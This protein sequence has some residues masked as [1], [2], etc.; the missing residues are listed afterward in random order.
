MRQIALT[1]SRMF[2]RNITESKR[3]TTHAF[4]M[5]RIKAG[6]GRPLLRQNEMIPR[7]IF[8]D[9]FVIGFGLS[10]VVLLRVIIL[11]EKSSFLQL[12]ECT[13]KVNA[14]E[15]QA[16]GDSEKHHHK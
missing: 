9:I 6:C 12:S 5:T 7:V 15:S 4:V 11:D 10:I 8:P 1:F 13:S 3:K 14:Q 2:L 16:G